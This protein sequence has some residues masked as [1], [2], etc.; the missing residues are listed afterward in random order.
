VGAPRKLFDL[1]VIGLDESEHEQQC[2]RGYDVASI[3]L[4]R[5]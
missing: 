5:H 1:D 3:R 4:C 2:V